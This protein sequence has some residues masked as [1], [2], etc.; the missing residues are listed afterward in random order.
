LGPDYHQY[1]QD[2]EVI[3]FDNRVLMRP[4]QQLRAHAS[5]AQ[6]RPIK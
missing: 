6:E 4:Y 3:L 1:A 2:R 5:A